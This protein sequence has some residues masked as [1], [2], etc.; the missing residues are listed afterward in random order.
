ME[1]Q[2]LRDLYT[3]EL[4][5][6]YDAENQ[7]VEAIPQ[8]MECASSDQLRQS[9]QM[10]LEQ[11]QKQVQRLEQIFQALG[12]SPEGEPCEAMQGL[13]EEAQQLIEQKDEIDPEVMDAALIAAAQ[14]V[15]HYEIASY[16]T[17]CTWAEQLGEQEA[18]NLLGQSLE[19]EKQTDQKLTTLAERSVNRQ[20]MS[21]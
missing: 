18:K 10:H 13:V 11:T 6:L 20:A 16:G 14:K 2:D 5:D 12:E 15:E 7:L 17:V 21:R 4:K 1:M 19:E 9:F 3:D 8:M